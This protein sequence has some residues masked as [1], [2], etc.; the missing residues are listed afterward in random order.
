M[1]MAAGIISLHYQTMLKQL[2]NCPIP[3]VFGAS[4]TGKTTAL[5]CALSLYGAQDMHFYSNITAENILQICANTGIHVGVD[6]PQ[7]LD[8]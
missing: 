2:Q 3:L 4:G 6:D 7:S 1:T 8:T 5:Q